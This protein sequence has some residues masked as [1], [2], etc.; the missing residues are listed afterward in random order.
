MKCLECGAKAT[1]KHHVIPK[2]LGGKLTI[3]L[4]SDCHCKIHGFTGN[5][6]NAVDLS[7]LGKYRK[8]IDS[9][10]AVMAWDIFDCSRHHDKKNRLI[11]YHIFSG[12]YKMTSSQLENRIKTINKWKFE[13]RWEWFHEI[14]NDGW[15]VTK[16]II[17]RVLVEKYKQKKYT[18]E[19]KEFLE[20]LQKYPDGNSKENFWSYGLYV[21]NNVWD[22]YDNHEAR[23][24]LARERHQN[25]IDF[26]NQQYEL[27]QKKLQRQRN[28]RLLASLFSPI[29]QG[30]KL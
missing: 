3:D 5:R 21:S 18:K 1:E 24:K 2:S 14:R 19:Y 11:S 25:E 12:D 7:Q 27:Q 15:N 30:I 13:K 4:C 8:H 17:L 9:F 10:A 22:L 28:N 23:H 16:A 6:I 20:I 26:I 29:F